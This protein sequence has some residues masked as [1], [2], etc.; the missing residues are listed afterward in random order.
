[1]L[2]FDRA[3]FQRRVD[4]VRGHMRQLGIEVLLLDECEPLEYLFGNAHSLSFYRAGILPLAAPP[5]MMPRV[6]DEAPFRE[7]SWVEDVRPFTDWQDPVAHV[8]EVVRASG[9]GRSAIGIDLDS[10]ALGVRRFAALQAAL[11]DAHFVDVGA[12]LSE[13][14]LVKSAAE[15]AVL[16]RASAIADQA[17]LRAVAAIHPG[18]TE[19]DAAVAASAAFVELGADTGACGPITSGVGAGFLHGHLHDRPLEP[20]DIVHMELTPRVGGY[21]ARL[22]RSAVVGA[23]TP[24]Q[25]EVAAIL[26]DL[27]DRQMAA[28]RTGAAARD[29]DAIMRDGQIAAGLRTRYDNITGYTL[30][31]YHRA[32]T[33]TSDFTR[34]FGPNVDY[35]LESGMVFHVYAAAQGLACSETV[36]VTPQGGQRLTL[37][38]RKLFVA[39]AA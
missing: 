39:G 36:L 19:R 10:Y 38:E 24:R 11:P 34:I 8:A 33:R 28:M 2:I 27:Q 29:V 12:M 9:Y 26:F 18:G 21:S 32:G 5:I 15:I 35:A 22:M 37:L 6:L 1:M 14:R 16:Q 17:M 13:V 25:Q 3:E 23:A 20:H 30:G 4:L 31:F 7:G